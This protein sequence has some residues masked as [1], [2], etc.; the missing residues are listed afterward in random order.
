MSEEEIY[1]LLFCGGNFSTPFLIKFH[2][3]DVATFHFVNNNESVE[4]KGQV[5][6]PSTFSYT[7]PDR[8]GSGG[9]LSITGID[10]K[11]VEFIELAND[12]WQLEVVGILAKDNTVEPIGVW[13]HMHG[14]VSYGQNMKLEFSLASD[15][16]LDMQF[17]A[18]KF[19][20]DNNKGNS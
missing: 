6:L 11:L 16:R 1:N 13:R 2:C 18:Y 5:Y 9:K 8:N 7:K 10:N 15:D 14:S 4:Y 19:D 3:D 17:C 12:K 20:T